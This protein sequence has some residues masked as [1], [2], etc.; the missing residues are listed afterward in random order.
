MVLM[1]V[2]RRRKMQK[3][4]CDTCRFFEKWN[5]QTIVDMSANRTQVDIGLCRRH[6]PAILSS[7]EYGDIS[8]RMRTVFPE[9]CGRSWCGDHE[10]SD[11]SHE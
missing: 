4:T 10:S 2:R 11:H 8:S 9:V 7:Q 1:E 3:K 5:E 6:S